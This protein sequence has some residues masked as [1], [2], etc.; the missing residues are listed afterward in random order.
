MIG[1]INDAAE[2]LANPLPG[3]LVSLVAFVLLGLDGVRVGALK[4]RLLEA[5]PND[6]VALDCDC[7]MRTMYEAKSKQNET[8]RLL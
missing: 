2:E 1:A 6:M 4:G 8:K 7:G 5:T 3:M